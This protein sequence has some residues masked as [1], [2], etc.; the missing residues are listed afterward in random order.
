MSFAIDS[1]TGN[2]TI[3]AVELKEVGRK[4]KVAQQ[5][6]KRVNGVFTESLI[7]VNIHR[8]KLYLLD[9]GKVDSCYWIS[10]AKNGIGQQEGS[11]KTPLG[12][13][14][15]QSKIGEGYE[16]FSV[17]KSRQPTGDIASIE[18]EGDAIVG[19][20][21][22][23]KGLQPRFNLGE[24]FKGKVVDTFQRYIYI[25]GTND[26][27]RIGQPVSSGCIRMS[28]HDIIDIFNKITE[29]T[30]VYVYEK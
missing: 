25:H 22:W 12:L 29:G 21:L 3:S 20:I 30:Y 11:G 23:L 9:K 24:N 27:A 19:R 2:I 10:T 14:F 5:V 16:P 4:C 15:V 13:H 17:F 26:V 6:C 8:Q 28:P 7:L 18:L 1:L